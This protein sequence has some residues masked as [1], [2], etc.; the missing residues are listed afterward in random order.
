[1][2]GK[3]CSTYY[4]QS[5]YSLYDFLSMVNN[6]Y[7]ITINITYSMHGKYIGHTTYVA[8]MIWKANYVFYVK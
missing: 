7:Y 4:T 5:T 2:H 3:C 6:L 1:M 8:H